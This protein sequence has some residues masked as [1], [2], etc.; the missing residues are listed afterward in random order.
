MRTFSL[1][2]RVWLPRPPAAVF[3]FFAD[4]RNLD[5]LTPPWLHFRILTPDPIEMLVGTQIAYRLRF[6]GI[7]LRWDSEITVWDPPHRFV[8]VQRRG[9]YRKWVHEH[10]FEEQDGGTLV[11]DRVT[12]AVLGGRLVQRLLVAPD[13]QRIFA[14]RRHKL[15][16]LFGDRGQ[17]SLNTRAALMESGEGAAGGV[18]VEAL[19]TPSARVRCGYSR[20]H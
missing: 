11:A 18:G 17:E 13:L 6:R 2:S 14:Y 5:A 10:T 3:E 12:Y 15:L 9:P 7:P 19:G 4:A 8:D 20:M 1:D 16:D